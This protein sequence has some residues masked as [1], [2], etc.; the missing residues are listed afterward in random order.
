MFGK[1]NI[2]SSI[3]S[4]VLLQALA[5]LMLHY[6]AG[7]QHCLDLED[8]SVPEEP[9]A[10]SEA[11]KTSSLSPDSD[12]VQSEEEEST[13]AASEQHN[14][15]LLRFLVSSQSGDRGRGM[16]CP[17]PPSFSSSPKPEGF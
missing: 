7:L 12:S 8:S 6:C 5:I 9:S 15:D 3:S 4:S 14:K 2:S 1:C 11:G 13:V 10:D 16:S 17:S